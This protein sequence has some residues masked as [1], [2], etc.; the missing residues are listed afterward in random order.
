VFFS[1]TKITPMATAITR[2]PMMCNFFMDFGS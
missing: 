2:M 1:E